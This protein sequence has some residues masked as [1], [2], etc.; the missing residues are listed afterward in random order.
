MVYSPPSSSSV[1]VAVTGHRPPRIGL[2]YT[3]QDRALLGKFAQGRLQWLVR[4]V[5]PVSRL[6]SGF[7]QGWDQACAEAALE[8]GIPLTAAVP[9]PGQESRW[10][11][12][13][14]DHYRSLLESASEVVAVCKRYSKAAFIERDHWMV[15]RADLV[16]A[17]WDGAP[18]GGTAETCTYAQKK[19]VELVN[20][21]PAW[22]AFREELR[23]D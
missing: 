17:L 18:H 6:I 5:G 14:Q 22:L 15:D 11:P 7:A 12:Q 21:W 3:D 2:G 8:M 16:M 10:P 9:L 13:A 4:V 23:A 20:V 19:R 1:S